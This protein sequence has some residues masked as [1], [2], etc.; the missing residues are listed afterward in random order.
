MNTPEKSPSEVSQKPKSWSEKKKLWSVSKRD[1]QD[2]LELE[3]LQTVHD[4]KRLSE[5]VQ[6]AW[7]VLEPKTPMQWNWHHDLICE[8]L[9][10]LDA[11][12]IKRLIINVP[13]RSMKSTIT[14]VSYPV[15]S[16][17][18]RPEN[19]FL[20]GSYADSLARKHSMLRRALVESPWH[21]DRWKDRYALSRDLNTK[22]EI[23]NTKTGQ[24][25]SA[26]ILGAITGE[27]AD[28][29][30]ID[31]PHN[32]KGAESD[33]DRERVVMNF[34]LAW[35]SRLNDKKTGRIAVIMQRL[36]E[37]D[38]TGHL[39]E[40]G[41]YVHL[42]I[43]T[44]AEERTTHIFPVSGRTKE[45]E[46]GD[47]LH[48]EREGPAEVE[49]A[50]SDLQAYGFAGQHQ[51]DPKPRGGSIF[52]DSMFEIVDEMP[53]RFEWSFVTG[54]TAYQDKKASDFTALTAWGMIGDQPYIQAVFHKQI[55]AEEV[56][57]P[58]REFIRKRMGDGF[59]G[60]FIEPKG[61][62]I[63]LNQ[64]LPKQGKD[65]A[66]PVTMPSPE[67]VREFFKDRTMNKVARAH[68]AVP[69]LARRK[70]K[71]WRGIPQ[72]ELLLKQVTS[73]PRAS[74]D[75]F[76]DTVI[77]GIKMAFVFFGSGSF[78]DEM[79][80]ADARPLITSEEKDDPNEMEW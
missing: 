6:S 32:P 34:D 69:H 55:K 80:G 71:V 33:L 7:D 16:W 37:K 18:R 58:A 49:Q 29:I 4:E 1:Y 60:A 3:A 45:R 31:D 40:Q 44:V 79:I 28:I 63:Y 26:G 54:D 68:N 64:A 5:F 14:T 73:F 46:A 67:Q 70:I 43:P 2:L 23:G 52:K 20:F 10:A 72:I 50:R 27:G 47:L 38:L 21:Q 9:E 57:E 19:R 35:T 74:H 51:Q 11:G 75:D 48:P 61:H 8:H 77:D 76:T 17:L 12:Q 30:I 41:G 22:A 59:R 53:D 62:G 36:H 15:W 25:K 24:M 56:E 13:P 66:L 42:K 39:L 78:T 65:F